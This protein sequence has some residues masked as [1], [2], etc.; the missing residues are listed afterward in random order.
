MLRF[1]IS[2]IVKE[3]NVELFDHG[4]HTWA[5]LCIKGPD[6]LI[7]LDYAHFTIKE[8]FMQ[9]FELRIRHVLNRYVNGCYNG[10]EYNLCM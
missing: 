10:H 2:I 5:N 3:T 8:S 1:Y 7:I 9:N 4:R 6:L